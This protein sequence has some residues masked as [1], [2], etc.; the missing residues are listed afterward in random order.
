LGVVKRPPLKGEETSSGD[1]SAGFRPAEPFFFQGR[2]AVMPLAGA[3]QGL[4]F[5]AAGFALSCL[6]FLFFLSFFCEL[7]PLPI[8]VFLLTRKDE[9]SSVH[10]IVTTA[11]SG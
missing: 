9:R 6:G 3:R 4:H 2:A 5:L 1:A 8:L 10:V 11:I 7:L